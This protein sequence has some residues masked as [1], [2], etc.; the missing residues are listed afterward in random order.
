M[1]AVEISSFGPPDVLKVV[2]RPVPEPGPRDI[3]VRV[4]A[5]GIARADLLQRQGKYPPPAAASDIP[6]LDVAGTV[7]RAG[8]DVT[9]FVPG[10]R[11]C[12][13]LTGGGYAEYCAVP[14]EQVLPIPENWSAVEAAT[15]P[16]NLF[17]VYDNVITRAGLA[18]NET[19]LIHGGSS[20][21]GTTAIMLATSF[22]ATIIVTAGS[23]EKCRACLDLGAHHAINYRTS[24][25]VA[26]VLHKTDGR[27]VDV[28]LDMVGGSYLERNIAVLATEGRLVI[29]ATQGGHTAQLDIAQ[30]MK[31]RARIMG[32]TMRAR[33]AAAKGSVARELL[34]HVWPL[35]PPKASIRPIIDSTYPLAQAHLAHERMEAKQN[36]GKIV[37]TV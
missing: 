22:N 1:K 5:A 3:L 18:R 37:L 30:L 7:E 12:A 24:D 21:I 8:A 10:D 13:I 33:T 16:E 19:I 2:E 34:K 32:S 26:E 20:G 6:G 17:T 14:L 11:V 28:I 27:G 25:F 9:T 36:I 23:S 29:I 35:L 31:R 4:E 15:L